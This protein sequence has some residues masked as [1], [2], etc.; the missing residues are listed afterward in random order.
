MEPIAIIGFSFKLPEDA[1]DEAG[2]WNILEKGRN[3]LSDSWPRERWN[4]DAFYDPDM[5]KD[6]KVM[7]IQC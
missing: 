6:N 1:V 7:R 3:V 5:S 4:M 2:F